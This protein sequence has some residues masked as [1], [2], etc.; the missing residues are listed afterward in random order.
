MKILKISVL[1]LLLL[2]FI[3]IYAQTNFSGFKTSRDISNASNGESNSNLGLQNNRNVATT[4]YGL[5]VRQYAYVL[6]GQSCNDATIIYPSANNITAGAF[7]TPTV[8]NS[9]KKAA[10]GSNY[11]YNMIYTAI[12]YENIIIP[13][14]PPGCALPGCT[15]GSDTTHYNWCIYL[16]ALAPVSTSSGYN[17]NVPPSADLASSINLY[18]YNLINNYQY[19]GPITCNDITLTCSSQNQQVQVFS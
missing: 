9:Q 14:L 3:P 5:Y 12:Y 4:V 16:G 17:A 6:P 8:I 1:N 2:F 10:I 18:N 13:V 11:L 19:L 15:W 7:L